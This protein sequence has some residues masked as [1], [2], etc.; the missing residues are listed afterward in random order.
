MP[1]IL[2]FSFDI[3]CHFRT[4]MEPELFLEVATHANQASMWKRFWLLLFPQQVAL[5]ALIQNFNRL[6]T[7]LSGCCNSGWNEANSIQIKPKG[8]HFIWDWA[9]S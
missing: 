9:L 2:G 3:L 7:V 5:L 4:Q 1:A 6:E 8:K